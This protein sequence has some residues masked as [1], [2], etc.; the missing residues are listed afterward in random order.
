[1]MCEWTVQFITSL[2]GTDAHKTQEDSL[3]LHRESLAARFWFPVRQKI[4]EP[5]AKQLE[6]VPCGQ[7]LQDEDN[8]R[9]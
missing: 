8:S 4:D 7:T 6:F 2:N 3:T 1:M 9:S 5:Q